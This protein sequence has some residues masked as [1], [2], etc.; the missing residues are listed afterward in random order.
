MLEINENKPIKIKEDIRNGLENGEIM[1]DIETCSE[2]EEETDWSSRDAEHNEKLTE[3]NLISAA[4]N[5]THGY[6]PLVNRILSLTD[7]NLHALDNIPYFQRGIT[8][9]WL[10]IRILYYK[11]IRFFAHSYFSI[12]FR[13]DLQL[14]LL[15]VYS[16]FSVENIFL[17]LP[18]AAYYLSFISMLLTTFQCLQSNRDFQDFRVWSRLFLTYSGG[19][20]N[21][22]EAEY[23][24]IKNNLKPFGQFFLSLLVNLLIYPLI[25]HEWL[26]QSEI[27]LLCF[28]FM[29]FTLFSFMFKE[30]FPDWS[31]LL[32]FSINVLA[33][34]PYETDPVVTQ[35]WRFLDLKIPTFASYIV[36]N[37]IE[38]CLNFRVLLYT[39]IPMICL[40]IASRQKWRG[41]YKY[42]IPHCV[43]LSWLQL[44]VINSQGAT[45]LGLLR[46]TLALV[47]VVLFLPLVGVTTIL[48]PALAL[49]KWLSDNFLFSLAVFIFSACIGLSIS[50]LLSKTRFSKYISIFQLIF[51]LIAGGLLLSS[52]FESKELQSY[53]KIESNELNWETFQNFCHQPAWDT[54]NVAKT[55]IK[56]L[57]IESVPVNWNGY[58]NDI[59]LKSVRNNYK[60]IIDKFPDF[61]KEYLN[62]YFGEKT[63]ENCETFPDI[64]KDDCHLWN[65]IT[66][67]CHLEK[68]NRYEFELSV[69]MQSGIWGKT[70]E[71]IL[72]ADHTF[73]NFTLQLKP[74]DKIYFK[75]QLFNDLTCDGLLGGPKPHV[76]LQEIGCL[77]CHTMNLNFFKTELPTYD[78]KKVFEVLLIGV[79][80]VFN[81]LLNPIFVF[82]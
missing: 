47:G 5:Y 68:Y 39:L 30:R 54:E 15:L 35:G 72:V 53:E 44:V 19:S 23:Q 64:L 42:L 76:S 74:N 21:P 58:L 60:Y 3:D 75:G 81:I 31:I 73:S 25:A 52:V 40:G 50:F 34:Y 1:N 80:F 55:Q 51:A 22:N 63:E 62:C 78:I 49:A 82:K 17:F 24:F 59:K 16:M 11:L 37:G 77:A 33:K 26:P 13:T 70:S 57:K 6:L 38:F 4:V 43:T 8:H 14:L 41:T 28:L 12:F 7:P 45:M 65:T 18:M 67:K 69:K 56:C 9:P 2:S 46:S 48:L 71:V 29:F 79:K 27:T 20:L 36:G 66:R 10:A 61:L 32:S